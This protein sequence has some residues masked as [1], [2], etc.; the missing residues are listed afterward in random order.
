M[1]RSAQLIDELPRLVGVG[2]ESS[3]R[4]L[5]AGQ[6]A[7]TQG[8]TDRLLTAAEVAELLCIKTKWV[9]RKA[10]EGVIPCVHF[11]GSRLVRFRRDSVL[12]WVGD[13]E[14]GG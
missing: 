8:V 12:A 5:G 13:Q 10:R 2:S 7:G 4:R 6:S 14:R 9:Q 3:E 11:P 1:A